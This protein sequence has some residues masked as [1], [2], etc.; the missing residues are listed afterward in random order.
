MGRGVNVWHVRWANVEAI[1]PRFHF[2]IG[3][4]GSQGTKVEMVPKKLG[5]KSND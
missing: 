4:G 3:S 2:R 5:P 1:N